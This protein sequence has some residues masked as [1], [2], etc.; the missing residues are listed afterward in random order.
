MLINTDTCNAQY[1]YF[2]SNQ[3][4]SF[5]TFCF[6]VDILVF[7]ISQEA[8]LMHFNNDGHQ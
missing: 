2:I 7:I 4:Y 6:P 3:E 8:F 5:V 1:F